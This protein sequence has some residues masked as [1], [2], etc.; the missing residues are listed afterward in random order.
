MAGKPGA[1][2]AETDPRALEPEF[3]TKFIVQPAID[4]PC[5]TVILNVSNGYAGHVRVRILS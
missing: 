1:R 5:S 3:D 2:V 4:M